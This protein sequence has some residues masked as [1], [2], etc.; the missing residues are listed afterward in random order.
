MKA[1][2]VRATAFVGLALAATTGTALAEDYGL[3]TPLI[4]IADGS[5]VV[6]AGVGL[7]A[8]P[9]DIVI[10]VPGNVQQALLY[11]SGEAPLNGEDDAIDVTFNN[12]AATITGGI[13]GGGPDPFFQFNGEFIY[14]TTYRA[15]VTQ[16]IEPGMNTLTISGLDFGL[17]N[18]GAGLM[19]I[20]DD[21]TEAL[22]DYRDG[23]DLAYFDFAPPR[24]AT[25]PQTY[26]FAPGDGP[27]T[28]ELKMFF[29]S[30]GEGRPSRVQ[31][32]IT[33]DVTINI[34][35]QLGE[36]DGESWDTL[37]VPIELDPNDTSITVEAI[38]FDDGS[39]DQPASMNWIASVLDIRATEMTGCN[40]P[41]VVECDAD[42]RGHR[43]RCRRDIFE[44]T[45]SADPGE[46]CQDVTVEGTLDYG[47]DTIDVESG[48]LVWLLRER[49]HGCG[50]PCIAWRCWNVIFVRSDTAIFTATATNESGQTSTCTIDL[51]NQD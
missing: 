32:D 18:S 22:I 34:D 49:R 25:N 39:G 33:G 40:V 41:P 10:D 5:G 27:R 36:T 44:V 21:G 17:Y 12:A 26:T 29:A 6:A 45:Y 23:Q 8:Q 28:A 38:S 50:D 31:I 7:V 19:V 14:I 11:W 4:P 2:T 42:R 35:N 24:D 48:N 20:Y 3:G 51:K 43:R 9:G 47:C 15:D 46:G 37:I 16:Y 1:W 13:I 30:V